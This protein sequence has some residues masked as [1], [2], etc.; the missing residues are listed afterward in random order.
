MTGLLKGMCY[1]QKRISQVMEHLKSS[2][3]RTLR[4]E[5]LLNNFVSRHQ[6]FIPEEV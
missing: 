6:K 5:H 1:L 3:F 4:F 2:Y